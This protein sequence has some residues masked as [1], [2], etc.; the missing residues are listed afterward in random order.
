[1]HARVISTRATQY[2]IQDPL[3]GFIFLYFL[4]GILQ[5]YAIIYMF[6]RTQ[7]QTQG[8]KNGYIGNYETLGLRRVSQGKLLG[9]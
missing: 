9:R 8:A 6:T 2:A 3:R 5:V 4:L 1:M 7:T